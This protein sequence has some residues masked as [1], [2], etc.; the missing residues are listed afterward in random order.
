MF[1][2]VT[3]VTRKAW[4]IGYR[5]AKA[6]AAIV[7]VILWSSVIIAF[8]IP[9]DRF[10]T[11][12]LKGSDF[13]Y[14]YT[15][16]HT[17]FEGEFLRMQDY[18]RLYTRQVELVPASA[19][20]QHFSMYPPNAALVFW[21]IAKLPYNAAVLLW[22]VLTILGF[23]GTVYFLWH[24]NRDALP[25]A[26]FLALAAAAFPPLWSLVM[27]GQSTVLPLIAFLLGWLALRS[28]RPFVAGLALGLLA[29]KPH[30]GIVIGCALLFS[31]QW[32]MVAGTAV[33]IAVQLLTV[34]ATMGWQAIR[35]Y[36][37]TIRAL[38][39][40]KQLGEP[41]PHQLHSLAT[42]TDLL[43]L[44]IGR[45]VWLILVVAVL[46]TNV[47]LWR[48]SAPLEARFGVPVLS[49]V[50]VSP[51]LFVYDTVVLVI[52]IILIGSWL[53]RVQHPWRASYW[54]FVYGLS[55]CLLIPTARFILVQLSVVFMI[56][57]FVRVSAAA[58]EKTPQTQAV[59]A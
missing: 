18:E 56:W 19:G 20:D 28:G 10:I 58:M 8:A 47:L 53:E 17:A 4:S 2:D 36:A 38:P 31:A 51:H 16:G 39:Q 9:G 23:A 12:R 3:Q 22:V 40:I 57:I 15:L 42:L 26:R 43:P 44:E 33:S 11:G 21:P 50:L 49:T 5:E 14:F 25:D 6:H 34:I 29:L 1:S 52:P 37:E 7:A 48:S 41:N 27:F 24:H 32:R 35:A 55:L 30:F 45:S 59:P 54:Q 46:V 13:V